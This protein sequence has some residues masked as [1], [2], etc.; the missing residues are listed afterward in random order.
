MWEEILKAFTLVVLPSA[1]KF[2]LGPILGYKLNIITRLIGTVI[3]MMTT[4]VAFT[5]FG[6]WLRDKVINRF[7]KKKKKESTAKKRKLLTLWA[8][9]GLPGVAFLT[10]IVFT[11]IGGAIVAVSFRAPKK[12]ILFYMLLSAI[13]WSFMIN[14][15]LYFFGPDI[16]PEFMR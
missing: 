9:Y 13:F 1:I 8:K 5:F 6:D 12:K 10:P 7:F 16:L 14:G 2:F 15:I 11:P 3:G 4:V